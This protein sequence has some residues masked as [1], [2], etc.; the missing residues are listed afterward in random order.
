[1][2]YF[3]ST[4]TT[5]GDGYKSPFKEFFDMIE[6]GRTS[7][8]SFGG[9]TND[10]PKPQQERYLKCGVK[11]SAL[12]FKTRHFGRSQL[13]PHIQPGEHSVTMKVNWTDVPL[14]PLERDIVVQIVGNRVNEERNELRLTSNQF[15]SRI[16]NKRHLVSMLDRI[17]LS[18]KRLANELEQESQ[19]QG[20]EA[21]EEKRRE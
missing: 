2:R 18:A 19:Q 16:E 15:G 21:V 7:F 8:Q 9:T 14:T 5:S 1:M 13:P 11:E 10:S 3:S 20:E 12:R 4:Q 6:S 17:V